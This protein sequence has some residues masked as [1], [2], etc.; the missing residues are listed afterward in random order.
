MAFR[1][2]FEISGQEKA[3]ESSTYGVGLNTE[4]I[5]D[6]V[7]VNTEHLCCISSD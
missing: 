5:I 4:G 6:E 3:I 7:T 2:D 1:Y